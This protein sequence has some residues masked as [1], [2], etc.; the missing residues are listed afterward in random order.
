MKHFYLDL[1][2]FLFQ[3]SNYRFIRARLKI[4]YL[5]KN[6]FLE[7]YCSLTLFFYFLRL[8]QKVNYFNIYFKT[9]ITKFAIV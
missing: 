8:A 5:K 9:N 2:K 1:V 3:F 4:F 7:N 6:V